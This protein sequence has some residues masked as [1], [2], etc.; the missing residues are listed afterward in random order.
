MALQIVPT[1][2]PEK[3]KKNQIGRTSGSSFSRIIQVLETGRSQY[4]VV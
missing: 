4:R 1:A 3:K 2:K